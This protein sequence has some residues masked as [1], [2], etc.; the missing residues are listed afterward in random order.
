MGKVDDTV[1][2]HLRTL[3]GI[4]WTQVA[5]MANGMRSHRLN[6]AIGCPAPARDR[7]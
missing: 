1:S 3:V 7:R 2:A 6:R 5:S 4:I